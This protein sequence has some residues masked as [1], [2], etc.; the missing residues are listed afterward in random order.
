[1]GKNKVYPC[2][3]EKNRLF[4]FFFFTFLE[5]LGKEKGDEVTCIWDLSLFFF[6]S[7]FLAKVVVL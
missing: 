1:M 6:L 4:L 5:P 2:P 3:F 7:V